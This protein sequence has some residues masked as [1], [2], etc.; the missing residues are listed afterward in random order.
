MQ[1][2]NN[3]LFRVLQSI[4]ALTKRDFAAAQQT[5]SRVEH[6]TRST[7]DT[8]LLTEAT[9]ALLDDDVQLEPR[10]EIPLKGIADP[11]PASFSRKTSCPSATSCSTSTSLPDSSRGVLSVPAT[12]VPEARIGATVGSA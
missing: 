8:I 12:R 10:G 5:A 11:V 9:R 6:L 7:G 4:E 2:S 3:A 1:S